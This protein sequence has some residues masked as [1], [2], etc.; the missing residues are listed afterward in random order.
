RKKPA[1]DES[2]FR[3]GGW[4]FGDLPADAA[5]VF[6]V[7]HE[8][9]RVP[10]V[11]RCGITVRVEGGGHAAGKDGTIAVRIHADVMRGPPTMLVVGGG[12]EIFLAILTDAALADDKKII[13]NQRR[14][15]FRSSFFFG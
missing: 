15:R 3:S 6:T 11:A 9:A 2:G 4:N 8:Y 7:P 1:L 13:V 10:K 14:E 12:I 5:P